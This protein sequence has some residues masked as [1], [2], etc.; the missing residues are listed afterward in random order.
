MGPSIGNTKHVSTTCSGS[1]IGN[2]ET[3]KELGTRM[4]RTVSVNLFLVG[5]YFYT[6]FL[7]VP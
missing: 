1:T 7:R 6:G 5:I 4:Q 2:L 3:G